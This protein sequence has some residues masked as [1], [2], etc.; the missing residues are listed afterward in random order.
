MFDLSLGED[1]YYVTSLDPLDLYQQPFQIEP[2]G[3]HL[4]TDRLVIH[5]QAVHEALQIQ[6][7]LR[8]PD[9]NT[10]IKSAYGKWRISRS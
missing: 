2:F 7:V 10:S 6:S 1:S 3:L 9:S 4:T 5:Q 8:S